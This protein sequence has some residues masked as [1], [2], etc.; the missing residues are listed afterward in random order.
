MKII[1]AEK[2][3]WLPEGSIRALAMLLII[4]CFCYCIFMKDSEGMATVGPLMGYMI[5]G[6]SEDRKK[7]ETNVK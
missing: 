4:I 5:K 3:L 7:K 2:P 1:D 6:Y